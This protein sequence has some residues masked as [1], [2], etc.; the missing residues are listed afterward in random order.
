MHPSLF[1]RVAA[2]E[3]ELRTVEGVLAEVLDILAEVK[4]NQD[5]IRQDHDERRERADRRPSDRGRLGRRIGDRARSLV[6]RMGAP[7]GFLFGSRADEPDPPHKEE[8]SF[9]KII[10]RIAIAGLFLMTIFLA[11]LY[12]LISNG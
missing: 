8:R 2:A 3:E 10:G 9:W 6:Q 4:A 11:G 12:R 1:T 7:F 5:M